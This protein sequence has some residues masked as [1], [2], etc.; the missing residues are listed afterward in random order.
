MGNGANSKMIQDLMT[1]ALEDSVNS[2]GSAGN[3]DHVFEESVG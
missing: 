2:L 3:H 1:L